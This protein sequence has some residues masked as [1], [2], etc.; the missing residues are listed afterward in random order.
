LALIVKNLRETES[1]PNDQDWVLVERDSSG[2]Y[3]GSGSVATHSRGA[4]FY[5]PDPAMEGDLEAAL[6]KAR[7]WAEEHGVG[8]VYVREG[9]S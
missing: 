1:P 6:S 5:V 8:T 3:A 2:Q 9:G 4:T 7:S